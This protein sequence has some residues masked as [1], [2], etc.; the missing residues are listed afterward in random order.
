MHTI[1]DDR[2]LA[3]PQT[4]SLIGQVYEHGWEIQQQR[5]TSELCVFECVRT[6][7]ELERHPEYFGR[8]N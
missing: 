5:T 8:L 7:V 4:R 2:L 6:M 3:C 1:E